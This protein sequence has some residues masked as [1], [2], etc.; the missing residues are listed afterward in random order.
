M[1]RMLSFGAAAALGLGLAGPASAA[2]ITFDTVLGGN[3]H[4]TYVEDGFAFT[5]NSGTNSVKCYS[6]QCLQ[7]LQQGEITTMTR[8]DGLDFTLE[9]FF[10]DLSGNTQNADNSVK[11]EGFL[12][13]SS[14]SVFEF[15]VGGQYGAGLTYGSQVTIRDEAGNV[16]TDPL[17][18]S[19]G[20]G[21]G[22]FAFFDPAI[23]PFTRLVFSSDAEGQTR[24]DNINASP[25]PL[26][27]AGWMLFGALGGLAA[28]R[29]RRKAS[30]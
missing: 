21:D 1:K 14:T 7:E 22:Y 24:I 11:I 2:L 29:R 5:P 20:D 4:G 27:A 19:T 18:F 28:L 30:A 6:G 26:P 15:M 10:F 16:V 12:D 25:V 9:S 3:P 17:A 13:G 8:V 23:G